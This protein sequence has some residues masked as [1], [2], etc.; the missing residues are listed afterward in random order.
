MSKPPSK[1]GA[2]S[3]VLQY[4]MDQLYLP[5]DPKMLTTKIE[6]P[7]ATRLYGVKPL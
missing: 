7:T 5:M 1:K 2:V 3:F 4:T 6:A